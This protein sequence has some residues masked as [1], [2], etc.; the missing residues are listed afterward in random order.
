MKCAIER[1]NNN[2]NNDELYNNLATQQCLLRCQ[3]WL[4]NEKTSCR[5]LN[6]SRTVITNI[7]KRRRTLISLERGEITAGWTLFAKRALQ[8][9]LVVYSGLQTRS[10]GKSTRDVVQEKLGCLK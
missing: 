10:I 2:N 3:A 4:L 8:E 5:N 7:I 1:N 9:E 6:D